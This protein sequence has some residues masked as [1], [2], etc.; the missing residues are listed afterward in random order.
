MLMIRKK[1]MEVFEHYMCGQFEDR[2]VAHVHTH[3]PIKCQDLGDERLRTTI[4]KGVKRA[5]AYKTVYE[6]DIAKYIHLVF[7]FHEDFDEDPELPWAIQI[8]NDDTLVG[9]STRMECLY[10]ESK[11]HLT[12]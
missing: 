8:L 7:A 2:M 5:K 3:F 4:R 9:P 6:S 10:Q 11:K 1:Q 12:I